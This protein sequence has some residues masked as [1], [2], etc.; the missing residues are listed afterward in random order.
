MTQLPHTVDLRYFIP[1]TV[2]KGV[3]TMATSIRVLKLVLE[4]ATNSIEL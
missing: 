3:E 1:A 2:D 4:A